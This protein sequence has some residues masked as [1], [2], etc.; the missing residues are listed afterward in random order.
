MKLRASNFRSKISDEI[1][2]EVLELG[3]GQITFPTPG[4]SSVTLVDKLPSDLHKKLFPE[5]GN[6]VYIVEPDFLV[7]FDKEG[8]P[9]AKDNSF[10]Y[11]IASHLL[12]HLAQPFRMLDEIYRVLRVGGKAVIFL[13]DRRRTFDKKRQVES[14]DHF[15]DEYV[16]N[17]P[18]VAD[19]DLFDFLEKL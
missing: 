11:V 1:F 14:F 5:L 19:I 17:N 8:L 12:E 7:D 15:S 18:E 13:P 10:D 9:F 4:A 3:P 6:D 2:G 16:R